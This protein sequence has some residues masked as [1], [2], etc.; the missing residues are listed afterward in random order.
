MHQWKIKR[1]F[2]NA[3][4]RSHAGATSPDL[5]LPLIVPFLRVLLCCLLPLHSS[6]V[7]VVPFLQCGVVR[8]VGFHVQCLI[9]VVWWWVL[10]WVFR[11]E[12][13]RVESQQ[14]DAAQT[15]TKPI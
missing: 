5:P 9:S 2:L 12:T 4:I 8:L 1:A 11:Y 10:G 6:V 14:L 7:W 13:V 15:E 3:G